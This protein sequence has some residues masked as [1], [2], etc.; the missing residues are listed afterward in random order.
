MKI[1]GTF[2]S[3]VFALGLLCP[4][5]V[6]ADWSPQRTTVDSTF[7]GASAVVAVDFDNDGLL[8][9]AGA[10]YYEG[11]NA[12]GMLSWWQN[13]GSDLWGQQI[14]ITFVR[15]AYSLR[16]ADIDQDG[17]QDLMVVGLP[18]NSVY[19]FENEFIPSGS[20]TFIGH[21]VVVLGSGTHPFDRPVSVDAG[22]LDGDGTIDIAVAFQMS[23][24]PQNPHLVI[25]PNENGT[26]EGIGD[27]WQTNPRVIKLSAPVSFGINGF[28]WVRVVDFDQDGLNDLVVAVPWSWVSGINFAWYRN[29]GKGQF[30][31]IPIGGGSPQTGG[32][33][34]TFSADIADMNN[35]GRLDIITHQGDTAVKKL[36][37]FRSESPDQ[38]QWS[39]IILDESFLGSEGET[40]ILAVDI[41][42][43]GLKDIAASSY[44]YDTKVTVWRNECDSFR[45]YHVADFNGHG[46][47]VGDLNQDGEVEVVG[48][49]WGYYSGEIV[50]W[51]NLNFGTCRG[52]FNADGSI[53]LE[54]IVALFES[55]GDLCPAEGCCAKD[56]S[57]DRFVDGTDLGVVLAAWG[58]CQ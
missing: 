4:S 32:L 48:G 7:A 43:D 21:N 47:A 16:S 57:G 14:D 44:F 17:D 35:D 23:T 27:A 1:L 58:Q 2:F 9:L 37:M 22:D 29:Q 8:D 56:L 45:R 49:S 41:D 36:V 25:F 40:S 46:I 50:Y 26:G 19:W 12:Y 53:G 34:G 55:W 6:W 13:L 15:G 33:W 5:F 20:V 3:R 42:Q 54:D 39:K 52:D 30:N 18:F 51:S 10:G 38:Q 24:N 31:F 11:N 28:S